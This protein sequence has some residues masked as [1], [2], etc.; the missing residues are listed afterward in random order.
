MSLGS[1]KLIAKLHTDIFE[2]ED[3]YNIEL[4]FYPENFM[5]YFNGPLINKD[6]IEL[7][8][9]FY[10]FISSDYISVKMNYIYLKELSLDNNNYLSMEIYNPTNINIFTVS[11]KDL[12]YKN[13]FSFFASVPSNDLIINNIILDIKKKIK[14]QILK[15]INNFN[16]VIQICLDF[17]SVERKY[18]NITNNLFLKAFDFGN[19]YYENSIK[20]YISSQKKINL[21]PENERKLI[22][23][24]LKTIN[25]EIEKTIILNIIKTKNDSSKGSDEL[26]NEFE[27]L[28]SDIDSINIKDLFQNYPKFNK[29]LDDIKKMTSFY[30]EKTINLILDLLEINLNEKNISNIIDIEKNLNIKINNWKQEHLFVPDNSVDNIISNASLI[31]ERKFFEFLFKKFFSGIINLE[32][33][34][35]K[36]ITNDEFCQ[37][38]INLKSVKSILFNNDNQEKFF[39]NI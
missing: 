30:T 5:I 37:I 2:V 14:N 8:N 19:K 22:D 29:F 6:I 34:K 36:T 32:I 4:H 18:N 1:V 9:N 21:I 17:I 24:H 20:Q 3:K 25:D 26:K 28:D 31:I 23:E 33:N 13:K 38:L 7:K 39:I 16:N 11:F 15:Y 12:K 10:P 35:D 27:N